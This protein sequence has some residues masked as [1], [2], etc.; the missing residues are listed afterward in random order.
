MPTTTKLSSTGWLII[1]TTI[2]QDT[3]RTQYPQANH[4]RQYRWVTPNLNRIYCHVEAPTEPAGDGSIL[5]SDFDAVG[6]QTDTEY[7]GNGFIKYFTSEA[8]FFDSDQDFGETE[9]KW[10][11]Y[12]VSKYANST[13]GYS[14]WI[15]FHFYK[16]DINNNDTE[17]FN[18][19]GGVN[20][21]YLGN[22]QSISLTPSGSVTT[23]DRL[24]I[25]VE[26]GERVP[27]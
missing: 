10:I 17:L 8:G 18:V 27:S 14:P 4:S 19:E 12:Y 5:T 25:G 11:I 24:R 22:G 21:F 1:D 20:S 6:S 9:T 3:L 2:N 13:E 7:S 23:D 26:G 15:R 16:R